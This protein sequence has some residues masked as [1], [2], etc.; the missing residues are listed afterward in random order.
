VHI[1]PLLDTFDQLPKKHERGW[2]LDME[3]SSESGNLLQVCRDL[4]VKG[5]RILQ[6]LAANEN[7]YR[8]IS[9]TQGQLSKMMAPLISDQLHGDHHDEWSII[10]V[11]SLEFMNLFMATLGGG[12]ETTK[13]TSE[14]SRS[15]QATFFRTLGCHKCHMLLKRQAAHVHLHLSPDTPPSIVPGASGSSSIIFIWILLD[16]FLLPYNHFDM[17]CG[18]ITRLAGEKMQAMNPMI[19]SKTEATSDTSTLP[20][21]VGDVIGRL[22]RICS[23]IDTSMLPSVGHVIGSL[24]R[25][26]AGAENNAYRTH[27]AMIME[28]LC[29][30]YNT[31]DGNLWLLKKATANVME[32]VINLCQTF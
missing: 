22:A 25:T 32:E 13:L 19:R 6:K 9:N 20:S 24:A 5:L 10:A 3:E 8:V 11:Q 31:E 30:S 14:V 1:I 28:H 16:I 29:A 18:D 12:T 26:V 21:L 17:M 23:I 27:A 2:L 7:N 15:S 4:A